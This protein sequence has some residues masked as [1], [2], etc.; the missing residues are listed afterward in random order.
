MVSGTRNK[1]L[2]KMPL[3]PV[4]AGLEEQERMESRFFLSLETPVST[5]LET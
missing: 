2:K 4:A 1:R 3:L 5:A